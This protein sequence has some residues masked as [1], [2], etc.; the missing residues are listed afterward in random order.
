MFGDTNIPEK[1]KKRM[2]I[3][4]FLSTCVPI[5]ILYWTNTH[6]IYKYRWSCIAFACE[7]LWE[8][9]SKIGVCLPNL[10]NSSG[11]TPTVIVSKQHTNLFLNECS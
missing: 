5:Q 4:M 2:L 9:Q 3:W 1:K 10:G 7:I 8:I 11:K 6:N